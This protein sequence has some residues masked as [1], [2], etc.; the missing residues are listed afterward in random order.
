M[1]GIPRQLIV[2]HEVCC[3][4]LCMGL[5]GIAVGLGARMPDLRESSPSKISSGFGGTLSLV[6]SSLFIMVVV[7]V[8]ALPSHLFL[9]T[10]YLAPGVTAAGGPLSWL[11]GPAGTIASLLVV[12]AVG[13]VATWVPLALGLQAFRQLEP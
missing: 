3:A 12:V 5:S 8:A 10:T 2:V 13:L 1:L 11:N 7:I 6:L 9:A 4:V